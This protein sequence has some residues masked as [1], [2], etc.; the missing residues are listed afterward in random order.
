[1]NSER[2]TKW[3]ADVD[4]FNAEVVSV[5]SALSEDEILEM[6]A[7]LFAL[8]QTTTH[9]KQRAILGLATYGLVQILKS[10]AELEE[11]NR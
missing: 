6:S 5:F 2:I 10:K 7:V 3:L 8:L 4:Q 11:A 1:M 9:D